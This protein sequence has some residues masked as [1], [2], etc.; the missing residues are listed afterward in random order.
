MQEEKTHSFLLNYEEY[1]FYEEKE[2]RM[3]IN[4]KLDNVEIFIAEYEKEMIDGEE[5]KTFKRNLTKKEVDKNKEFF[6]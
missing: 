3:K 6:V 2:I 4:E 5:I 1:E